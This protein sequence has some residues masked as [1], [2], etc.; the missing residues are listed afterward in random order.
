ML[1]HPE[2][3]LA[4]RL[5]EKHDLIPPFDLIELVK[6][7]ANVE[8]VDIPWD[9]DGITLYLKTSGKRPKIII[10]KNTAR[11][12]RRF[13]LA[14]E[15]GHVII[16]W[17]VGNIV[18]TSDFFDRDTEYNRYESEAHRFAAELLMPTLW[19]QQLSNEIDS[20]AVILEQIVR[21]ADVSPPAACIKMLTSL[22]PGYI[23]AEVNADFE[24]IA[25]GRSKCTTVYE[26]S[27]SSSV[28]NYDE[29]YPF[30]SAFPISID[31]Y[32]YVWWKLKPLQ[33]PMVVDDREWRIILEEIL[34][35][36]LDPEE[37]P[38]YK[39]RLNGFLA[40][41]NDKVRGTS[42]TAD[43]VFSACHHKI[44]DN[45]VLF[46]RLLRHKSY[47]AFLAKRVESFLQAKK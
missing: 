7:Y 1:S 6:K 5:V 16:P 22:P 40:A 37:R 36:I 29:T 34:E 19:L 44:L 17:H 41:A 38:R 23:F 32:H 4:K 26:P 42:R 20:P 24:V 28:R 25:S 13:T 45:A 14:H 21:D 39:Q 8:E 46:T 9:I 33:C 12:R 11:R 15:L 27:R 18:D 30:A 10:N 2:E 43:S 47:N 31:G 35:E 3:K